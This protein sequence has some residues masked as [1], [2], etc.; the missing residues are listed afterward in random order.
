MK[1]FLVYTVL[2]LGLFLACFAVIT[3][4]AALVFGNTT[5]VWIWSVVAAAVVSSI[6]SLKLL[7]G[8]RERFAQSVQRRAQKAGAALERA[9]SREDTD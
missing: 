7:E 4:L 9:R 2:R 5:T 6:L 1:H 3:T 8:P